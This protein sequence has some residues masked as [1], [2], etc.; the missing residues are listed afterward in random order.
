MTMMK[1]YV[2][3]QR[4]QANETRLSTKSIIF[5]DAINYI[6][7]GFVTMP[8]VVLVSENVKRALSHDIIFI[9]II[10]VIITASTVSMEAAHTICN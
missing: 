8:T 10:T 5:Y 2:K 9:I 3:G 7:G 4:W 6:V 1:M